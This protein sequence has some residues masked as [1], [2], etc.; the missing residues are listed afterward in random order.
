M[1]WVSAT[2]SNVLITISLLPDGLNFLY[3]KLRLSYLTEF[4]LKYLRSMI[5][6]CK[7][8]GIR[9]SDFVT[10]TDSLCFVSA[11]VL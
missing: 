8:M 6:C 4:N 11:S 7:D 10:K 3:L 5:L 2:N 1:K 9:K